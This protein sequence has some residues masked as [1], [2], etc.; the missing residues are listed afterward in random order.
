[1]R[2]LRLVGVIR[3]EGRLPR[4]R[5]AQVSHAGDVPVALL[6]P[7]AREWQSER[8]VAAWFLKHALELK[9]HPDW[10]G[11]TSFHSEAVCCWAV[12]N[13]YGLEQ[14]P[15]LPDWKRLREAGIPLPDRSAWLAQVRVE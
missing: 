3:N 12:A 9:R 4:R 11:P 10:W 1:M 13:G 7:D 2:R 5:S 14:F 15:K 6:D 8:S